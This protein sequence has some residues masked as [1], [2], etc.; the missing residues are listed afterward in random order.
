[1]GGLLIFLI[2][3]AVYLVLLGLGVVFAGPVIAG[4]VAAE[5]TFRFVG[6]YLAVATKALIV[7][8]SPIAPAITHEPSA[9]PGPGEQP[10]Y[11]HYF[12]GQ[13][14]GDVR[15]VANL[16]WERCGDAITAR[17][18]AIQRR[19][20]DRSDLALMT[21]PT[22]VV[23]WVG[24][25]VGVVAG[26]VAVAALLVVL[27]VVVV[28]LQLLVLATIVVLRSLDTVLLR[29]RGIF[30]HCPGCYRSVPYPSYECPSR[31][32]QLRHSNVRPGRYGV[33]RRT[34]ACRQRLPTLIL[35]GSY[36]L[37]AFCPFENCG[38]RLPDHSGTAPEI[39]LPLLG[40]T[41][42]GK[43]R[44]MLA[45]ALTLEQ[46]ASAAGGSFR[47]ADD[48]TRRRYD[49]LRQV[50]IDNRD[51]HQTNTLLP[52]AHAL[53]VRLPHRPERLVYLFDAAGERSNESERL[54][55][56]RYLRTAS[57]FLFV[58]DPLSIDGFWDSLAR[59]EQERLAHLR[60]MAQPPEFVFQQ[61]LHNIQT[62]GV[63][64]RRAR[65]AVAISKTDLVER[66]SVMTDMRNESA[67]IER[68]LE[69]RLGLDNLVR[70]VR[71]EFR[72]TTF[73]LTAAITDT[74]GVVSPSVAT[75]AEWLFAD[76]RPRWRGE[77]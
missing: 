51:T 13:C 3:A 14:F 24:V 48:D 61:V 34:C 56:L 76:T 43:T 53:Y 6:S 74:K 54:Q 44:L 26:T 47:T 17:T 71:A 55:E 35:L 12:F 27:V 11:R 2:S 75:L 60:V 40:A 37:A 18:G 68:W 63:A 21:W 70:L 62:M 20:F 64:T 28:V 67:W 65:L 77:S 46:T 50:I 73:F 57:S 38:E 19:L 7:P 15:H 4:L 25:I 23:A 49:R 30:I 8:Q 1:M 69:R 33:L 58:I 22:A 42:A 52:R 45:L 5:L 41:A 16:A 32:C 9:V 39:H 29:L 59:H 31:T 66:L 36:R 10:A 72:D